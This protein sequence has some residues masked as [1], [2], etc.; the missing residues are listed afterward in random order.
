M[1]TFVPLLML[2]PCP[3]FFPTPKQENSYSLK[4]HLKRN[5]F[6]KALDKGSEQGLALFMGPG[7]LN[8]NLYY[9]ITQTVL[10]LY[11][12]GIE[13]T[14]HVKSYPSARNLVGTEEIFVY[15]KNELI[16]LQYKKR[17]SYFLVLRL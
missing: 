15:T 10:Q 5:L 13:Q 11:T 12:T 17:R 2:Y 8:S 7:A 16:N 6:K 3:D 9:N 4:A 14:F 1:S